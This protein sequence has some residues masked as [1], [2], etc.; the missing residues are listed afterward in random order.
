[1]EN[2]DFF[3]TLESMSPDIL[4]SKIE[5]MERLSVK[6]GSTPKAGNIRIFYQLWQPFAYACILGILNGEKKPVVASSSD[7]MGR[8]V[9][10]YVT[11]ENNSS[12][13]FNSIILSIVALQ[14]EEEKCNILSN[15]Q[16]MNKEISAYANYGLEE[17]ELRLNSEELKDIMDLFMEIKNR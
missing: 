3:K 16:M 8:D 10:K 14:P 13:I 2:R 5:V 15:P 4:Q 7:Q 12:D 6:Q 17:L 11:I 1:M 9:F